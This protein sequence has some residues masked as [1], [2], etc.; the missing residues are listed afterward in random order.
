MTTPVL[1]TDAQ[2]PI[3]TS[4][5]TTPAIAELL[6]NIEALNM[7]LVQAQSQQVGELRWTRDTEAMALCA[8]AASITPASIQSRAER[9]AVD[10]L[11]SELRKKRDEVFV[12]SEN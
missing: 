8:R 1:T 12:E 3:S 11:A 9:E 4:P 2:A 5:P 10:R 6:T 7:A